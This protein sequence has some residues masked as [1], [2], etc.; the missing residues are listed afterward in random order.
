MEHGLVRQPGPFPPAEALRRREGT[1]VH[2]MKVLLPGARAAYLAA[3]EAARSERGHSVLGVRPRDAA[4][5]LLGE[6]QQLP[7]LHP[8]RHRVS[9][10]TRRRL[11]AGGDSKRDMGQG[12]GRCHGQALPR[13]GRAPKDGTA[14]RTAT[15]GKLSLKSVLCL[16][17]C[18][19][20]ETGSRA[21]ATLTAALGGWQVPSTQRWCCS[22]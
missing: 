20:N 16:L 15:K 1:R 12:E 2:E 18:T 4:E 10:A 17:T 21:Q 14:R 5:V 6:I 19:E 8:C 7:V 11:R 13:A 3:S 22:A 9:P